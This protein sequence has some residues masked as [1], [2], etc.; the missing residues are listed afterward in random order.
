MQAI[1]APLNLSI[2]F[3]SLYTSQNYFSNLIAFIVHFT[4]YG[5]I[6]DTE[7]ADDGVIAGVMTTGRYEWIREGCTGID[8]SS[9]ADCLA[10]NSNSV[11]CARR[12]MA[13]GLKVGEGARHVLDLVHASFPYM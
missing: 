1:A 10:R 8:W 13:Y 5:T 7:R 2:L 12:A 11:G 4:F 3:F 6:Q 9:P